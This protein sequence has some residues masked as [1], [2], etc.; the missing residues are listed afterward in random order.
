MFSVGA[1]TVVTYGAVCANLPNIRLW[2]G[3]PR[4]RVRDAVQIDHDYHSHACRCY[5]R[6][7]CYGWMSSQDA[8]INQ[9]NDRHG[10][11]AVDKGWA[12][13]QSLNHE[14]EEDQ[15][16]DRLDDTEDALRSQHAR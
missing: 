7:S 15:R 10:S 6:R 8:G 13:T 3:T 16:G 4:Q 5:I 14:E 9:H 11:S 2:D 1:R 12:P